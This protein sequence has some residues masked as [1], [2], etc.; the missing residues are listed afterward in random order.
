[1]PRAL[2]LAGLLLLAPLALAAPASRPTTAPWGD[3]AG[4]LQV[5]ARVEGA[6]IVGGA[7]P[8]HIWVRNVGASAVKTDGAFAWLLLAESREK[9]S[10]TQ[11]VVLPANALPAQLAAGGAADFTLDLGATPAFTMQR[12]V[13]VLDGYPQ[14]AEGQAPQPAGAVNAILPEGTAVKARLTL[15]VP[16]DGAKPIILAS[17]PVSITAGPPELKIATPEQLAATAAE[18]MKQFNKDAFAAQQAHERAVRVGAAILPQLTELARDTHAPGYSRMWVV[19]TL[20]DIGDAHAVDALVGLL[21]DRDAG[22]RNVIAYHGPKLHSARLNE[23]ILTRAEKGSDAGF[24]AWAARGQANVGAPVSDKLIAAALASKEPRARAEIAAA[25]A[26]RGDEK[27]LAS[28]AGLL[29]DPEELVRTGAARA[30][31][32]VKH[33]PAALV[34]ALVASL[35]SPGESALEAACNAL[36][37]IS[38]HAEAYDPKTPAAARN[39]VLADWKAWWEKSRGSWK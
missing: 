2:F 30:A 20:I 9:A 19:T 34:S 8:L 11:K 26:A 39:K 12:G 22:V 36:G 37:K 38:G 15:V 7:V 29:G 6:A 4:G 27:S 35:D 21:D 16:V 33:A 23:A 17:G 18:L 5:S 28:L 3:A 14:P 10:Y 1:M 32:S 13:K 24:A 25:L 31:G